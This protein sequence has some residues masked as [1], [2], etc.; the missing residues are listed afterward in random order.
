[1]NL[2]RPVVETLLI[3]TAS[4]FPSVLAHACRDDQYKQCVRGVCVCL[5]KVGDIG[6]PDYPLLP[7]SGAFCYTPLGHFGPGAAARGALFDTISSGIDLESG[8]PVE[9][10]LKCRSCR[11]GR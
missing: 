3:L 8:R 1:M 2:H 11:K 9:A 10:T 5:P 4:T 6:T 7:Q